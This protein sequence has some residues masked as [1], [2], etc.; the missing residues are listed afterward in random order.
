[1]IKP[2]T[3]PSTIAFIHSSLKDD[4]FPLLNE[5]GFDNPNIDF[6]LSDEKKI[7]THYKKQLKF[8][9]IN[10]DKKKEKVSKDG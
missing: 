6:G 2:K 3:K 9:I 7:A 5:I 10:D 8:S 1:M 4:V